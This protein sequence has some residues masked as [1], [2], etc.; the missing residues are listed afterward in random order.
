MGAS[1]HGHATGDL[2]HRGQKR[3]S[4][5][6]IRD[7]FIGDAGGTTLEQFLGLGDIWCK[8]EV[9]EK[10]M[11]LAKLCAFGFLRLLDLHHQIRLAPNRL[12]VDRDGGTCGYVHLVGG[13][14]TDASASLDRHLMAVGD[15]LAHTCG[16]QPDPPLGHLDFLRH[17]NMHRPSL[18]WR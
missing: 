14:D 1:L 7:R 8:V 5:E 17:A 10:K 15:E 9:R 12:R 13:A 2:A 11:A 16:R 18:P 4:A 6:G 3:Q